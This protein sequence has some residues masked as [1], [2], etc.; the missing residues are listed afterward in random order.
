MIPPTG[1]KKP[2]ANVA[3]TAC[4]VMITRPRSAYSDGMPPLRLLPLLLLLLDP[5]PK[6]LLLELEPEFELEPESP[7]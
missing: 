3:S 5:P 1:K 6:E 7:P 4:A 2:N